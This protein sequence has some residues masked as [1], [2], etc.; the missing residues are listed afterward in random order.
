MRLS[1]IGRRDRLLDELVA[2]IGHAETVT[3]EGTAVN[4]RVAI[5][6]SGRDAILAAANADD[7][8][9]TRAELSRRLADGGG[10]PDV[11]LLIRTSGE[12]RLSD[13]L[14]WKRPTPN[15]TSPSRPRPRST[16]TPAAAIDAFRARDR[17]SAA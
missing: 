12:Q 4:L 14:L 9:L 8:T 7:V 13:F 1:V 2:L 5:D 16:A 17:R 11:D 15:S 3:R 10:G 6:Y